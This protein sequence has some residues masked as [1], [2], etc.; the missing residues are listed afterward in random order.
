MP[1][2]IHPAAIT[3]H[4]TALDGMP[5]STICRKDLGAALS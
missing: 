2:K 3:P 5:K 4:R 1:L